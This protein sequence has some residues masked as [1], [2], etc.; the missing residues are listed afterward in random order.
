MAK[1]PIKSS[2]KVSELP[3]GPVDQN[4]LTPRQLKILQVHQDRS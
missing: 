3:D 2:K 4:G 1:K